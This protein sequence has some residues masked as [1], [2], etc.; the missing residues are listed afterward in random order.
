MKL[1]LTLLALAAIAS[2]ASANDNDNATFMV[3]NPHGGY[4]VIQANGPPAAIPFFGNQGFATRV[5]QQ[6][7]QD[8]KKPR[9]YILKPV[10]QGDGHSNHVVYHKIYFA[11]AE[12]AEA[13]KGKP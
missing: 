5:I 9:R 11:T 8:S 6:Q 4:N 12:E 1:P 7:A 2:G 10:S 13:A 3:A